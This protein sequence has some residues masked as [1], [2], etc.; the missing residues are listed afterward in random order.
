MFPY[1]VFAGA[2]A[3]IVGSSF[4]IIRTVKGL[5]KPNRVTF[6][7]WA[8]A[9][10]IAV[11]A[12]LSD[13]V[14]LAVLPVFISG[15]IPFLIFLSSFANRN[16]YWKLGAF[17]YTCG[18]LSIVALVLWAMTGNPAL[19]IV[20]AIV[21]DALAGLPTIVKAWKYPET[22]YWSGYAG[23]LVSATTA[24]FA[25]KSFT[26]TTIAFPIYLIIAC[27]A[28]LAGIIRG[29]LRHTRTV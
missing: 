5:T 13:G 26:I 6:F 8:L 19:A 21:S 10:M 29:K 3:N 15:F 18:A 17:D 28:I 16:A 20:F 2:L 25:A 24:F 14:G 22:E 4:Y 7:I 11:A 1:L 9:P 27:A 12:S 23:A